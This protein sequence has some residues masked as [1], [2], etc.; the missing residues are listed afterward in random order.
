MNVNA[1]QRFSFFVN[2]QQFTIDSATIVGLQVRALANLGHEMELI[3]EGSGSDPDR[4]LMDSEVIDL[5]S[6][7]VRIYAK[8]PTAFGMS[9][10]AGASE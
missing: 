5:A 7:T 8:P 4:V 3:V 2:G 6:G 9:S 1:P 10:Y